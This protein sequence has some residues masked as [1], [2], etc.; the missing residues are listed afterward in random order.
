MVGGATG[1]SSGYDEI[2]PGSR[3]TGGGSSCGLATCA[4]VAVDTAAISGDSPGC[5]SASPSRVDHLGTIGRLTLVVLP[6]SPERCL[7]RPT[8]CMGEVTNAASSSDLRIE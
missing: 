8:G 1:D 2:L 6:M 4:R 5:Q 3:I 7:L